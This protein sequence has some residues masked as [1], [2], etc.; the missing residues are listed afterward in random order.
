MEK[1]WTQVEQADTPEVKGQLLDENIE[2]TMLDNDYDDRTRRVFVPVRSLS[3]RG[4][5]ATTPAP[6]RPALAAGPHRRPGL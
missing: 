3:P 4:G 6:I 1:A 2:W 5:A